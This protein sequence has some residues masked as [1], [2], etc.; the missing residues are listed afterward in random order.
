M[1]VEVVSAPNMFYRAFRELTTAEGRNH[2]L[3]MA[4]R[5]GIALE[6]RHERVA[7]RFSREIKDHYTSVPPGPMTYLEYLLTIKDSRLTG[8]P[9]SSVKR[10]IQRRTLLEQDVTEVFERS[11]HFEIAAAA[12]LQVHGNTGRAEAL[13]TLDAIRNIRVL[14]VSLLTTKELSSE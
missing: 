2:A 9:Y 6:P 10:N 5:K 4:F 7:K 13:R 3:L 14:H 8:D 11:G 12:E 1:A